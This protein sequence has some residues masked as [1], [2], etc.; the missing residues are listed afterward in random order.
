MRRI[1]IFE[2]RAARSHFYDGTLGINTVPRF[3]VFVSN[4]C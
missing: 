2:A 4:R 1:E 3:D